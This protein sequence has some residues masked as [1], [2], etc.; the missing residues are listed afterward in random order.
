MNNNKKAT[1]EQTY[2][3]LMLMAMPKLYKIQTY[4]NDQITLTCT[5][6]QS[7][8]IPNKY[9]LPKAIHQIPSHTNNQ[10]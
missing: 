9:Q 10:L 7:K 4:P 1:I 6:G 2:Q 5:N 8:I 3:S